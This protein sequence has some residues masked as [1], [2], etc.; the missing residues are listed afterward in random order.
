M[1]DSSFRIWEVVGIYLEL[2]LR[3]SLETEPVWC[4]RVCVGMCVVCVCGVC[5]MYECV[6]SVMFGCGVCVACV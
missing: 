1:C 5:V 6:C 2:V 3:F 4:A